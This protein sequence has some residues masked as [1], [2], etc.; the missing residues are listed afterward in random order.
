MIFIIVVIIVLLIVL[1]IF[2]NLLG[3]RE[4]LAIKRIK[5]YTSTGELSVEEKEGKRENLFDRIDEKI[6]KKNLS[7][8]I[9]SNL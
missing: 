1:F 3:K 8:K 2:S 9:Q 5:I 4:N 7:Q 6:E